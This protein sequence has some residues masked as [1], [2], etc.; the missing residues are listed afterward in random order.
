MS[1]GVNGRVSRPYHLQVKNNGRYSGLVS[2]REHQIGDQPADP[3]LPLVVITFHPGYAAGSYADRD[4]FELLSPLL[5]EQCRGCCR[6]H[7]FTV[8]HPGY[9][10]P[11]SY[12]VDRFD[13]SPYDIHNQP[14][15]IE[16][17]LSWLALREY[18]DEPQITLL[19]YGHSMGGLALA[20]ADL[21]KLETAVAAQGRALALQ[22]VLSAPALV[23]R[24]EARDNLGRLSALDLIK[25]TLGRVPLYDPV[26][27]SLFR[28]VA[29][30][31]WRR[32]AANYDLNCQD[33]FIDFPRYNPYILLEQGRQLL[34]LD[35]DEEA[36]AHLLAGTQ[37]IL[38]TQDGMVDSEALD[39]AADLARLEALPVAVHKVDSSHNAE[40]EDPELIV[41]LLCAL[42]Q[43]TAVMGG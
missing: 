4:Y 13:L 19:A 31:L 11:Q 26:A 12:E 10:L 36:L 27:Q 29:P 28:N 1:L 35:Y 33:S 25:R 20:R 22:K 40:R 5:A 23:L 2:V 15:L 37:L 7:I 24:Q 30:L 42:L 17:V 16:Q 3:R 9:D 14:V 21:G 41:G 39:H 43:D 8:N 34:C 18:A 6:L 38:S 32:D